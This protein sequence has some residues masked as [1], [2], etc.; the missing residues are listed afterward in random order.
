M[1]QE[2]T[3]DITLIDS[4][5][6]RT[7]PVEDRENLYVKTIRQFEQASLGNGHPFVTGEDGVASLIGAMAVLTSAQERRVVRTAE[8]D[9]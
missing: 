5:G 3:G 1:G 2:P 9:A 6:R 8:F 7:V 4:A